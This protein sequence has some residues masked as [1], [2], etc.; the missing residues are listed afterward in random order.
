MKRKTKKIIGALTLI[1][2][3]S[4]LATASISSL[5]S[6]ADINMTPSTF[7]P[8]VVNGRM[9]HVAQGAGMTNPLYGYITQSW[10][11]PSGQWPGVSMFQSDPYF[12]TAAGVEI[13]NLTSAGF[14]ATADTIVIGDE[15]Y[16]VHEYYQTIQVGARTN[17]N[18]HTT[19]D[20]TSFVSPLCGATM[21][22]R[23]YQLAADATKNQVSVKGDLIMWDQYDTNGGWW[24]N[25]APY[26]VSA[27]KATISSSLVPI[28]FP[29]IQSEAP[30]GAYTPSG[31][32]AYLLNNFGN[33]EIY[34][35]PN[36]NVRGLS[37]YLSYEGFSYDLVLSN[38][39]TIQVMINTRGAN[40]GFTEVRKTGADI[41]G[42]V[43]VTNPTGVNA[44]T[45]MVSGNTET[46]QAKNIG[47]DIDQANAA[48]G[49]ALTGYIHPRPDQGYIE[50]AGPFNDVPGYTTSLDGTT[51]QIVIDD[52]A[53]NCG[54][55]QDLLLQ[56]EI[57]LKP[58]TEIMW[59][60]A[61]VKWD[62]LRRTFTWGNQDD[63]TLSGTAANIYW[64]YA[65]N[66]TNVFAITQYTYKVSVVTHNDISM[67]SSTG[68]PIDVAKTIRDFGSAAIIKNPNTDLA[69]VS[70]VV[71]PAPNLFSWFTDMFAG[72]S[73]I[74]QSVLVIVV[75][76]VVI[77]VIIK[78]V[79]K[80]SRKK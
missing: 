52:P 45:Y 76:V 18:T 40:V 56:P 48:S 46:P 57:R 30:A 35:Y 80:I 67:V 4:I 39:T 43:P 37:N 3:I 28:Y 12:S 8:T 36:I 22:D 65:L 68:A 59:T 78:I 17:W 38:G 60:R 58:F 32:S 11:D 27:L 73:S 19:P 79:P 63:R 53:S 71:P 1:T 34:V 41:K 74:M 20:T 16:F 5:F 62:T 23:E 25:G 14:L 47:I 6:T 70:I 75:V 24:N 54:M 44:K 42:L 69:D 50:T 9:F 77:F 15:V 66:I 61:D 31:A 55:P 51:P 2:F 33:K 10:S 29:Q 13:T 72:L 64:P 49:Y 7:Q 26:A 21:G